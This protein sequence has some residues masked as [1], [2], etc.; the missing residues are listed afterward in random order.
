MGV[1]PPITIDAT[2]TPPDSRLNSPA[3]LAFFVGNPPQQM[4]IFTGTVA[5]HLKSHRSVTQQKVGVILGSTTLQA[6]ACSKVDLASITNSHSEFIFAVDTNTVE[7]D[8]S[9]GLITLVT[10]IGVQGT[11]SI[12]ERFTYHVEVLSNPVDTLI[13]GTVRWSES[14][15]AP[16]PSALAGQ[17]LFRVDAGV[18]TTPP[19]GTPQM[20]AP[21]SGFSHG[22]P[23]LTGG[24][25]AV[26]Y[27]I[28][29][30]PLGPTN[31]VLPTLLP[32]E[33][34]NLPAG[35]T[36]NSFHFAPPTTIQLTLAAPSAVG[37]D[38]EM[39]LDAGPR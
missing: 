38:F 36:D 28:D 32:N 25:W 24:T 29:N 31:V 10:D 20:Q 23:V 21:R 35:A 39:L 26:A 17:P 34:T 37:V 19:T 6:Q 14:L 30:V 8:P 15:G 12:F 27:Q 33:L 18:F 5:V 2:S 9:T 13:A 22:K 11:D 3:S 1:L 7:I 16:S 4:Q